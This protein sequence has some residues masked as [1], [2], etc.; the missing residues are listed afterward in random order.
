MLRLS[1]LA[2]AMVFAASDVPAQETS[3][4]AGSR[5]I[6]PREREIELARSA[7]PH[8]VSAH[9]RV[10][11]LIDS[12]YV[13]ADSGGGEQSV[14]CVVNRSWRESIEPQCYDREAAATIMPMELRRNE[15]RH[16]STPEAEIDRHIAA[17]LA[18]GEF[19]L[20]SR[21]AMTYMMSP[22]QLLYDDDGR[23]VGSWRPHLMIY[24]PYLTNAQLG[25]ASSPDMSVGM[26]SQEG[27]P[28]ATL[29]LVMPAFAT[30]PGTATK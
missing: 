13:M 9:A 16:R 30:A 23:R 18:S 8:S 15:L 5:R 21:P 17:G 10:L 1:I 26:V 27:T 29:M 11:V 7:A 28:E 24:Y 22:Q 14:T 3:T 20:P 4:R 19:R 6:L 25:L 12:A 2:A